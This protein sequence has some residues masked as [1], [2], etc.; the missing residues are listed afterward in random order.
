MA[1]TTLFA[2]KEDRVGDAKVSNASKSLF[3]LGLAIV[4]VIII[5]AGAILWLVWLGFT[6]LED[7]VA[8][9]MITASGGVLA[10]A[11]TVVVTKIMDTRREIKKELR[12]FYSEPYERFI[13]TIFD[14]MRTVR[15]GGADNVSTEMVDEMDRLSRSLILWGSDRAIAQWSKFRITDWNSM[16]GGQHALIVHVIQLMLAMRAD[17]GHKNRRLNEETIAS[18]FMTADAVKEIFHGES[19]TDEPSTPKEPEREEPLAPNPVIGG[20]RT[21]PRKRKRQ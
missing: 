19:I 7:D 9:A 8:K 16:P 1:T 10:A 11:L 18:I 20:Q 2:T 17:F 15:N 14:I 5:G 3:W 21:Q 6:S 12:Q 13:N 4:V